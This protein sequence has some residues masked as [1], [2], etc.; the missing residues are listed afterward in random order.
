[1]LIKNLLSI[2]YIISYIWSVIYI[3]TNKF[4]NRKSMPN[5][6]NY[7]HHYVGNFIG[8]YVVSPTNK[9][10]YNSIGDLSHIIDGLKPLVIIIY[11]SWQGLFFLTL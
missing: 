2:I 4:T 7:Y 3:N 8:D 6:K 11:Y 1:M 9:T 10:I 5:K